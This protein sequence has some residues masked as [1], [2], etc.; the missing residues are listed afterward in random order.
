MIGLEE[1]LM[2][3]AVISSVGYYERNDFLNL[4][5][6]AGRNCYF[7]LGKWCFTEKEGNI[8]FTNYGMDLVHRSG[9]RNPEKVFPFLIKLSEEIKVDPRHKD[10][11]KLVYMLKYTFLLFGDDE[12]RT[13]TKLLGE[14]WSM[15]VLPDKL[16]LDE[17]TVCNGKEYQLFLCDAEVN[18][19]L[20]IFYRATRLENNTVLQLDLFQYAETSLKRLLSKYRNLCP[21]DERL[22]DDVATTLQN[23]KRA[24]SKTM[25]ILELEREL[26]IL[27]AL[28]ET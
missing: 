11:H 3:G 21:E 12:D 28:Q 15:Q 9:Q 10:L 27:E 19:A 4:L 25:R 24:V 20:S 2:C 8:M 13:L 17:D 23:C 26:S 5:T 16:L 14:V 7:E 22:L 1:L 18:A 6:D